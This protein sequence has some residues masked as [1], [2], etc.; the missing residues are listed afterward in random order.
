MSTALLKIKQLNYKINQ[1]AILENIHFTLKK[2]QI[3]TIIG[4][5][6]AGK[7]TLIKL[8]LGILKPTSGV[9]EKTK[10]LTIG[11][12]P[13]K[14]RLESTIPLT[15][16]RF[17]KLNQTLQGL[18]IEAALSKVNALPLLHKEMIHLSGGEMQRVLMAQAIIKKPDLL[19]LDEPAQGVDVKGQIEFYDLMVQIRDEF[20]CS[21]IVISHDLHL[22]AAKTDE[23]ICL[24]KKICCMGAPILIS[25]HPEFIKLF[26][27]NAFQSL[28][29]YAHQSHEHKAPLKR[30]SLPNLG[31]KLRH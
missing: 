5:N 13:Q 24:N 3:L 21:V 31:Q 22:V 26:G 1:H 9:I 12:V 17:L 15:V 6:G 27:E 28:A 10:P 7:S 4:P 29:I 18:S 23:V 30:I 20:E 19:I 25:E 2:Q 11:Y 16:L 14:L 8:I